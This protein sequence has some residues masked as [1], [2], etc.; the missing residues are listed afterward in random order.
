MHTAAA[1]NSFTMFADPPNSPLLS[2]IFTDSRRACLKPVFNLV[3]FRVKV[4]INSCFLQYHDE[5]ITFRLPW[6]NQLCLARDIHLSVVTCQEVTRCVSDACEAN[7]AR[8]E[9]VE[10]GGGR[11]EKNLLLII[12]AAIH[13]QRCRTSYSIGQTKVRAT[14]GVQNSR[15]AAEVAARG[16]GDSSSVQCSWGSCLPLR[17]SLCGACTAMGTST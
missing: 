7:F 3:G 12:A 15:T 6:P 2:V 17:L 8:A 10:G 1:A 16:T 4:D 5:E 11:R 9:E 14:R 13:H